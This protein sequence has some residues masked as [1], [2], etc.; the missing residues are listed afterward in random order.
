MEGCTT[1][2]VVVNSGWKNCG[3]DFLPFPCAFILFLILTVNMCYFSN[4]KHRRSFHFG[5]Q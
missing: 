2:L 3:W 1:M 5:E 4:Q